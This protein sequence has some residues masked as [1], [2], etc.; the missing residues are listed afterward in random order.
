MQAMGADTVDKPAWLNHYAKWEQGLQNLELVFH[1]TK[2]NDSIR[3]A[4]KRAVYFK[5]NYSS[6]PSLT[7]YV[8]WANYAAR[9][10]IKMT[11]V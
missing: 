1:S 8:I 4:T 10:K 3:W 2:V 5:F 11:L 7:E 9:L 6:L